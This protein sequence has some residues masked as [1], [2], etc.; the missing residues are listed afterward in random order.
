MLSSKATLEGAEN[1]ITDR[2]IGGAIEVHR[3]LGPG[4][5]ES[6]YEECLCYELSQAGL[7]FQRQVATPVNYKGLK[8]DCAYRLDLVVEDSVIVEIKAIDALIP[9]HSSQLLTYLKSLNKRVGLLI[10]FNVPILKH[11]LKRIVN[12]YA[13]PPLTPKASASSVIDDSTR[14]HGIKEANAEQTSGETPRPS[15]PL[16]AS[17]LKTNSHPPQTPASSVI[18]D[19]TRR[20]GVKEANAEQT[21]GEAPRPSPP[22]RASALKTDSHTP[23]ASASSVIDDS[24]RRHGVRGANAEQISEETPRPSPPLRASALKTDSHTPQASASSVIDDSTRRRGATEAGAEQTSGETPRPS[25]PLRASALNRNAPLNTN[26][27]LKT[28]PP[29]RPPL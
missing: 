23:Q 5:L 10:N 21:S 7:S 25:S 2:I 24:T 16:G 15:S 6:A 20:H 3:H 1:T 12:R 14:R 8:L 17:A 9:I 22:L 19:S 28:H 27:A 11:G 13:G 29:Q 18:D 26:P 4:L